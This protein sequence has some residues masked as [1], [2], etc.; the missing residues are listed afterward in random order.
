MK[1]RRS[2]RLRCRIKSARNM[3]VPLKSETTTVSR[4]R[5][6]RSIS[7]ARIFTRR[8]SCSSVIRTRSISLRQF[9]EVLDFE[10]LVLDLATKILGGGRGCDFENRHFKRRVEICGGNF[11][12][13]PP[14]NRVASAFG[15]LR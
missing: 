13:E 10:F 7:R 1:S 14:A 2:G 8:A 3:T 5:K 15:T 9:A 6:S 12:F 11:H 4:P